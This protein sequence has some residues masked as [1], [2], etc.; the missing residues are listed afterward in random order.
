MKI[1]FKSLNTLVQNRRLARALP[2]TWVYPDVTNEQSHEMNE[3]MLRTVQAAITEGASPNARKHAWMGYGDD[4]IKTSRSFLSIATNHPSAFDALMAAGATV[5]R[6]TVESIYLQIQ[7]LNFE[8]S[9]YPGDGY[10]KQIPSEVHHVLTKIAPH[11]EKS[12]GSVE[13]NSMAKK[14]SAFFE[15]VMPHLPVLPDRHDNRVHTSAARV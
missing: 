11:L 13:V 6:D 9:L 15:D 8:A 7:R 1:P 2:D 10:M 14:I 12:F 4:D 3:K 5:D